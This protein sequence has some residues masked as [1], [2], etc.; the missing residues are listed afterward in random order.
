MKF[1]SS[2]KDGLE[3]KVTVRGI[4]RALRVFDSEH[5]RSGMLEGQGRAGSHEQLGF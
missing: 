5:W 2:R 3:R 4:M 1:N